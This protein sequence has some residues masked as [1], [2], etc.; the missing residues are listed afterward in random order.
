MHPINILPTNKRILFT[1][2]KKYRTT[3]AAEGKKTIIRMN[4][5]AAAAGSALNISLEPKYEEE[6]KKTASTINRRN[7]II[8]AQMTMIFK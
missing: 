4:A 5:K 1:H 3:T 6:K 7:E 2:T 8:C